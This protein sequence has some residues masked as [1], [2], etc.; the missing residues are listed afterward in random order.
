MIAAKDNIL[1]KAACVHVERKSALWVDEKKVVI[2]GVN[3][4]NMPK[5]KRF[6]VVRSSRYCY[7]IVTIPLHCNAF[8]GYI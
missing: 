7:V 1:D 6:I 3:N 4:K 5:V 2:T 8:S